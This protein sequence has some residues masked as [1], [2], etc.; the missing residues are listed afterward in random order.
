MGRYILRYVGTGAS[1]AADMQ[2]IRAAQELTVI[3]DSS[4]RMLL[5]EASEERLKE[6]V[7]SLP[8]WIWSPQ[9][10]IRLPDPRPKPRRGP[11]S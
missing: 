11:K 3:D 2:R 9:R 8:G 1:P 10:M 6:L 7:G 4:S 5:V